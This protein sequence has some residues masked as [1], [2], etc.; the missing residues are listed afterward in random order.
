MDE[1]SADTESAAFHGPETDADSSVALAEAADAFAAVGNEYRIEILRAL[2]AVEGYPVAYSDLRKHLDEQDT[3]RLNYHLKELLGRFVWKQ[4]DEGY[5]LTLS[6]RRLV[7]SILAGRYHD[8]ET[9]R[10]TPAPGACVSCGAAALRLEQPGQRGLLVCTECDTEHVNASFPI[11]AWNGRPDEAVPA[12]FDQYV[13]RVGRN[14]KDGICPECTAAMESEPVADVLGFAY[15]M[16]YDCTACP[17]WTVV[18]FGTLA[19]FDDNVR[20]F[21][22]RAGVDTDERPFWTV[23]GIVE[24]DALSVEDT[25]PLVVTVEFEADDAACVVTLGDGGNVTHVREEWCVQDT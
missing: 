3:G 15:A 25:D 20:T 2:A 18:P 7:S 14:A 21:L 24:Q 1:P 22:H 17:R 12:V 5:G 19:W 8:D 16:G 6:G 11:G 23:R 10:S 4:P 13:M 9:T